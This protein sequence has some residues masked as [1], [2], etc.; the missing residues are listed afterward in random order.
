[1][2]RNGKEIAGKKPSILITDGARNFMDAWKTEYKQKNFLDK[3]TEHIRNITFKGERNNNKMERLNGEIRDREKVMRSLKRVD[4]PILSGIQ[5]HH[6][7]IRSHMAL[8]G[9]TPSD[10]AGIKIEGNNKWITLIQNASKNYT[11]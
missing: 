7:F 9:K 4:S 5:I 1:M 10:M 6:N 3:K 8:D 11:E 2:F